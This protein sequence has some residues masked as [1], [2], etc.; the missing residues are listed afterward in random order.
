LSSQASHH[1]SVLGAHRFERSLS[2]V[3]GAA[4]GGGA[5]ETFADQPEQCRDQ[6]LAF[7]FLSI[8]NISWVQ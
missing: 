2:T 4:V 5:E 8:N 3:L 1:G 6:Y 7:V